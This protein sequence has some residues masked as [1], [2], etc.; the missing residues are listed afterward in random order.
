[1]GLIWSW[2]SG[3]GRCRLMVVEESTIAIHENVDFRGKELEERMEEMI[4]YSL[5]FKEEDLRYL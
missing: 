1:M 4:R 2:C 5:P 3:L